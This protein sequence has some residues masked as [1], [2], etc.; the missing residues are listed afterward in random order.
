M[1]LLLNSCQSTDQPAPGDDPRDTFIG[2]WQF[3][4]SGGKKTI[5][6]QSYLVTISKDAA[7]SSQLVLKN[8][9]NPGISN[10]NVIGIVTTNQIVVSSQTLGN[11]W[12]V[13]GS[14]KI[15]SA[16]KNTMTWTYSITAGGDRVYYTAIATRQ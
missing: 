16:D 13:D 2:G 1:C 8:F 6:S 11:G 3:Q 12:V 9:G 4:E 10:V 15:T 7:N 14:G 5:V